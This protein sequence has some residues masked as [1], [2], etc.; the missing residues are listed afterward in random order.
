VSTSTSQPDTANTTHQGGRETGPDQ[1]TWLATL[2]A[3]GQLRRLREAFKKS[4]PP[5]IVETGPVK[6]NILEGDDIDL[7]QFPVPKWQGADGGRYNDT[8]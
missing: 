6:E 2:E 5:R 8:K 3:A 1:S 4:I 7:S